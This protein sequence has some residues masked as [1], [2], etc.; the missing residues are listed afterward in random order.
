MAGEAAKD[1]TKRVLGTL[2]S[3][4]NVTSLNLNMAVVA[5]GRED[6]AS[7]WHLFKHVVDGEKGSDGGREIQS[8]LY[9]GNR[10]Y[11]RKRICRVDGGG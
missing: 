2:R 3:L 4:E 8:P 5:V 11:T 6:L 1:E 10:T 7:C 9:G